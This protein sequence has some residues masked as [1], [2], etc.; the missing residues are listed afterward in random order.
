MRRKLFL[1][2]LVIVTILAL[3]S[4][5]P[6]V[7]IAHNSKISQ[8]N[9]VAIASPEMP[10]QEPPAPVMI[11]PEVPPAPIVI[12]SPEPQPASPPTPEPT[13]PIVGC[14]QYRPLV[15]QYSWNVDVAMAVM[16]AESS[17]NPNAVNWTDNHRVCK[18]S[19]SLMQV[20]CFWY[21][22][23]GYTIDTKF[24]PEINISIAYKIWERSG[25]SP[26]STYTNGAYLKYIR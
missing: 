7:E 18:G 8:H 3:P 10:R 25:F 20:G 24:N 13:K 5:Q 12:T 9:P 21:P 26:W 23:F 6:K 22:H 14:E 17:C 4:T 11:T 16:Q 15:A 19:F 1:A 2:G